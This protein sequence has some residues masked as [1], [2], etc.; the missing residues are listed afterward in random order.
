MGIVQRVRLREG[1]AC[2]R[3]ASASHSSDV[4]GPIDRAKD[5]IQRAICC[6]GMR[7]RT[8]GGVFGDERGHGDFGRCHQEGDHGSG[9]WY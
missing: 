4:R 3:R 6:A 1:R 7:C 8:I 5:A 2:S 9:G